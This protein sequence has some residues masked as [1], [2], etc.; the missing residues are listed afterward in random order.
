MFYTY[1]IW[2]FYSCFWKIIYLCLS[3]FNPAAKWMDFLSFYPTW[4]ITLVLYYFSLNDINKINTTALVINSYKEGQSLHSLL[5]LKLI[6]AP[7]IMSKVITFFGCEPKDTKILWC[8][9][10]QYLFWILSQT[11]SEDMVSWKIGVASEKSN[12]S[13][14]SYFP[15][16]H[17]Q[18]K[19]KH[20]VLHPAK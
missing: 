19:Q 10:L 2:N 4:K 9:L 13:L 1:E 20:T 15:L 16:L 5:P 18:H 14:T 6:T 8:I 12:S 3:V 7:I 11:I 17:T